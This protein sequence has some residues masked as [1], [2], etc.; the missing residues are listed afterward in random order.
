MKLL[1]ATG[2][3]N[4]YEL[5]KR[6]LKEIENI[7]VIMPKHINVKIDVNEDGKTAEENAIKKAKAYYDETK[8][9]VIA[10]DSGLWVEK[11]SEE[12]QPGLFVKRINGRDDLSDEEILECY[13][14]KI[15]KVGGE[16]NARY[17]TGIAVINEKGEIH[18][19]TVDEELFVFTSNKNNKD[20]IKGGLLDVISYD[21][22]NKKYFNEL[23]EEEKSKR[24]QKLDE[25]IRNMI[26]EI[27]K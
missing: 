6:R 14:Q 2:N 9:A 23:T 22:I 1:F 17:K 7:E 27:L 13:I 3:E 21:P 4:K 25:E 18:S 16:T 26:K 8:L 19:K 5:M 10:E 20:Y 11:F 12:D 15:E 24:Y